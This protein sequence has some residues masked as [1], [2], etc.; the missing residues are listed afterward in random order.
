MSGFASAEMEPMKLGSLKEGGRDGTLIVVD[1]ALKR[2]VRATNVAPT[3]Q[4]ALDDWPTAAPKLRALAEA[5]ANDKA[6]GSFALDTKVLAA[7]LPRAFQWADG[8]AY[9][10]HVELVRKARGGETAVLLDHP[11]VPRRLRFVCRPERRDRAG[12]EAWGIDFG[13]R[14]ASSST[15]CRWA[16]RGRRAGTSSW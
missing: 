1:R 8:S 2:A 9:V 3:L 16:S 12:D 6:P 10:V 15:T 4:K 7:P 14:S 13:A 11:S 5:L